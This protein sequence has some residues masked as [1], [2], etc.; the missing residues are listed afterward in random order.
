MKWFDDK[1]KDKEKETVPAEWK[2]I[3]EMDKE[4]KN[5]NR[6]PVEVRAET[7]PALESEHIIADH[8]EVPRF[9]DSCYLIDRCPHYKPNATCYFRNQVRVSDANSI[10]EILKLLIEMQTERVLFASFIE[11]ME[12]GYTD[13]N[14]SKEIK[15]L[16]EMMKDFKEIAARP[17]DEVTIKIKGNPAK[18]VGEQTQQG[19]GIL[20][21]I[22]GGGMKKND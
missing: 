5:E 20:S 8:F 3:Q 19:G 11:K 22:F 7:K 21:Q 10:A 12:G 18:A 15:M 6:L 2:E 4:I 16:M 17:Q 9:C 13:A 14:L 1:E